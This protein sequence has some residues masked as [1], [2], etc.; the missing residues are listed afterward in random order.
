MERGSWLSNHCW[1]SWA[2]A[3]DVEVMTLTS[4]QV[5]KSSLDHGWEK[6]RLFCLYPMEKSLEWRN[7]RS[8]TSVKR[9]QV[10]KSLNVG[11]SSPI[12]VQALCWGLGVGNNWGLGPAFEGLNHHSVRSWCHVPF[13]KAFQCPSLFTSRLTGVTK[14]ALCIRQCSSLPSST[15]EKLRLRDHWPDH[16]VGK[17][18]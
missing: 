13:A 15:G 16:F 5:H 1:P 17:L 7:S 4:H 18:E 10:W 8:I 2:E 14:Q 9:I 11:C 6:E 3:R 12:P